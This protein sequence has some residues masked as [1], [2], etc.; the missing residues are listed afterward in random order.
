MTDRRAQPRVSVTPATWPSPERWRRVLL[1]GVAVGVLFSIA[2][3]FGSSPMPFLL[4]TPFMVGIAV[5]TTALGV[6]A[7]RLARRLPWVGA[8][9]ERWGLVAG[10]MMSLPAAVVVW[11]A[12]RLTVEPGA[13]PQDI[14]RMLPTAAATSI[15]FC[16]VAAYRHRSDAEPEVATAP[17]PAAEPPPPRFL[18]RLP[19]KLSG[20]EVW[21]VEA[22]DHYLRVHT[23]RGQD[24][25]L[26]RLSDAIAE[27]DGLPGARTH[28]SWWVARSAV[29]QAHRGDGRATLVLKNGVEAPVSRTHAASL[30]A[31]GWF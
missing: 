15:F 28:R 21:A 9:W 20:A 17:A 29:A 18:E 25:I 24:L 6:V 30:R 4:R 8:R 3:A 12:V 10:L 16:L 31:L 27:L 13:P 11:V 2:G 23:S 5:A 1:F 26:M 14:L 22:E 7:H 19:A